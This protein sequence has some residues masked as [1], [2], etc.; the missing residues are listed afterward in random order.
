MM[1]VYFII[2]LLLFIIIIIIIVIIQLEA[3]FVHHRAVVGVYLLTDIVRLL[4]KR[5]IHTYFSP[6]VRRCNI[7]FILLHLITPR[8]A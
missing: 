1:I 5:A 4:E 2:L 7:Y 6:S 8:R 3:L